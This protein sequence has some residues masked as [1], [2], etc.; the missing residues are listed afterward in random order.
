MCASPPKFNLVHQTVSPRQRVG[1]EDET[2]CVASLVPRSHPLTRKRDLWTG[3]YRAIQIIFV[4]V[5]NHVNK[6][7][8]TY[9]CNWLAQNQY[10]AH[11]SQPRKHLSGDKT[12]AA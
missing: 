2:N 10:T 4:V 11:L 6:P 3:D 7:V 5:L 8:N 12:N 1:S 9:G